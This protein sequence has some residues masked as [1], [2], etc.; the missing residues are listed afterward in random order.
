[1]FLRENNERA[2]FHSNQI[3]QEI[4]VS[5]PL[6]H[7]LP[8]TLI[9]L[10]FLSIFS[11][12]SILGLT[13]S[14][15]AAT[16][17]SKRTVF[18]QLFEWKWTDVA[19]E[20]ETYLGPKGF[21]AVQVSPPQEHVV[22]PGSGFPWWQNYQPVSY[23][24]DSRMGNPDCFGEWKCDHRWRETG[25]MVAFRNAVFSA[26]QVTDWWDNRTIR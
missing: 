10:V 12:P 1:V 19:R 20:C 7:F 26:H 5:R 22:N 13:R 8:R 16:P 2:T 25:K 6:T 15:S 23:K 3:F 4:D 9:I 21:K 11:L 24:I 14:A 17:D 18:V